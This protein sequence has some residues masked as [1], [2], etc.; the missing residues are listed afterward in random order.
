MPAAAVLEIIRER[1]V[2]AVE[3]IRKEPARKESHPTARSQ[4]PAVSPSRC[5]GPHDAPD[6]AT[7]G[8]SK[9]WAYPV[10]ADGRLYVRDLGTLWCYDIR[11]GLAAK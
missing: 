10:V 11:G 8:R 4:P 2:V 9:A 1:G 6:K 3:A 5:V 7:R